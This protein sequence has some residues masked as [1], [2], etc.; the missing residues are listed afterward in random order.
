MGD[1]NIQSAGTILVV[2]DESTIIKLYHE[3]LD[4]KG[5]EIDTAANGKVAKRMMEE[6]HYT[7]YLIDIR[8]PE[9]NDIELFQWLYDRHPE[10]TGSVIFTT[11][12]MLSE[13]TAQFIEQNGF[14]LLLKPFTPNE[15]LTIINDTIS[16]KNEWK[17]QEK[18]ELPLPWSM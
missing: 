13:E 5:L 11:G 18:T 6:K 17:I 1:A 2:E 9:M 7:L 14:T 12:D 15:F 16:A 4:S 10:K 3:V 8:I